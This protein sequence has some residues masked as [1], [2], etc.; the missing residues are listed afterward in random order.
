MSAVALHASELTAVGPGSQSTPNDNRLSSLIAAHRGRPV[1]INFWASWCEPCREEMPSLQ[2]L[3]DRYGSHRLLLITVAV[4]DNRRQ[5]EQ[6]LADNALRLPVIDDRD[7]TISRAWQ[8]RILP[9]TVL[10]DRRHRIRLRGQGAIDW[11]SET[12][13]RRLQPFFN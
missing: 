11:D 5:V 12:V 7:Q 2:R 8:V 3:A 4:A 1:L 10:L 13:T 9:G 6:F